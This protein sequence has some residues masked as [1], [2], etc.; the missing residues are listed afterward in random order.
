MFIKIATFNGVLFIILGI[1]TLH[2][3]FL[4]FRYLQEN[5]LTTLPSGLFGTLVKLK[6]L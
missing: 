2:L 4:L 1:L 3:C 5:K 6:V